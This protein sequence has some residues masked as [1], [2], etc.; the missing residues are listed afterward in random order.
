MVWSAKQWIRVA[1]DGNSALTIVNKFVDEIVV[2]L[3]TLWIGRP[4][5][6]CKDN[7]T[8]LCEYKIF[9]NTENG[10]YSMYWIIV[11]Y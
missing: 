10:L 4:S 5:S 11:R 9:Q 6:I 7:T 8:T 1:Y 2:I 3:Q